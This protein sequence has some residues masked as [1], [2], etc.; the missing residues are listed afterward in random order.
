MTPAQ[1]VSIRALWRTL[2]ENGNVLAR[3]WARLIGDVEPAELIKLAERLSSKLPKL[4]ADTAELIVATGHI[5][6]AEGDRLENLGAANWVEDIGPQPSGPSHVGDPILDELVN[7]N[8]SDTEDILELMLDR[9]IC[10]TCGSQC[11]DH[12]H[13]ADPWRCRRC[14]TE[15]PERDIIRENGKSGLAARQ[16]WHEL[17]GGEPWP[18]DL[19]EDPNAD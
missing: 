12:D 19:E 11:T 4:Y 3:S 18:D 17:T 1:A 5:L 10:P 2:G 7:T 15:W 13:E 16:R 6:E 14:D 8:N 9:C